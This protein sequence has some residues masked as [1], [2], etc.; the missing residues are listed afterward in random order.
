MISKD[1][2]CY[3]SVAVQVILAT[4]VSIGT[5]QMTNLFNLI[6]NRGTITS[7]ITD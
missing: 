6:K 4:Q 3:T 2:V 1:G 5:E 7:V